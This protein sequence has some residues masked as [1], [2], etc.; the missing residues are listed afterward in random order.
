MSHF[1]FLRLILILASV[2]YC[3]MP[4]GEFM[5]SMLSIHNTFCLCSLTL[6]GLKLIMWSSHRKISVHING[7]W[8]VWDSLL[9]IIASWRSDTA[10]SLLYKQDDI[11]QTAASLTP[12]S[13]IKK[14]FWEI[15]VKTM[16]PGAM[17][18]NNNNGLDYSHWTHIE[19]L[20]NNKLNLQ[21]SS[22][23]VWCLKRVLHCIWFESSCFSHA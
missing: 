23:Q 7:T 1:K 5:E 14:N 12:S 9:Q 19:W 21:N 2:T 8:A 16:I 11:L 4:Q 13:I 20:N 17:T 6:S 15:S 18:N 10:L 3:R 22:E